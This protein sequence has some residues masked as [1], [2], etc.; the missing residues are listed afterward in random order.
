MFLPNTLIIPNP[1]ISSMNG[2]STFINFCSLGFNTMHSCGK[3]G[4]DLFKKLKQQSH[5]FIIS[6]SSSWCQVTGMNI[7]NFELF[8]ILG[9]CPV[10]NTL[11]LLHTEGFPC[12]SV[13]H[14]H[15]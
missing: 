11:Q 6:S 5:E 13:T 2:A 4:I 10:E 8:H 14:V 1:D 15:S 12:F 9:L 3:N 7:G